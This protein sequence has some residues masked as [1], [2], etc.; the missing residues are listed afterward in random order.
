LGRRAFGVE[1]LSNVESLPGEITLKDSLPKLL[2]FQQALLT[3]VMTVLMME[4]TVPTFSRTVETTVRRKRISAMRWIGRLSSLW[5]E[6]RVP[7]SK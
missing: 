3:M 1:E 6:L 2:L 5:L 7:P 4:M